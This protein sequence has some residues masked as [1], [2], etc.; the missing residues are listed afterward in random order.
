MFFSE[1]VDMTLMCQIHQLVFVPFL[2][3]MFFNLFHTQSKMVFFYYV[4]EYEV[5][6]KS[7]RKYPQTNKKLI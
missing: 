3:I 1:S 2:F 6:L 5:Y 4:L 7:F